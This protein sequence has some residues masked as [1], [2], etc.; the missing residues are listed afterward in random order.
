[1]QLNLAEANA[2]VLISEL[3]E[4]AQTITPAVKKNKAIAAIV[5]AN[6]SINILFKVLKYISLKLHSYF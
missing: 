2:H 3:Y 1:M 5:S 4:Q 6:N